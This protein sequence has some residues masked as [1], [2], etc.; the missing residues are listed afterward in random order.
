MNGPKNGLKNHS[1][2]LKDIIDIV[3]KQISPKSLKI[4]IEMIEGNPKTASGGMRDKKIPAGVVI[5]ASLQAV[6]ETSSS[7]TKA[8]N[9]ESQEVFEY[10]S[11]KNDYYVRGKSREPEQR[12]YIQEEDED[13]EEDGYY[14]DGD[15]DL[16]EEDLRA[17]KKHDDDMKELTKIA[18]RYVFGNRGGL[19]ELKK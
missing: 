4:F 2:P 12:D 1:H 15:Q 7:E 8:T 10:N 13:Y 17:K 5:R 9:K 18:H 19:D 14:Q 11:G 6:H 16:D 3:G